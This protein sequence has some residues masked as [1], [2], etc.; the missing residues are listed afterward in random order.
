MFISKMK[1]LILIIFIVT[2][3]FKALSENYDLKQI[4]TLDDPW[5]SSFINKNEFIITEKTGKIKIVDISKKTVTEVKH[6][7][8]YLIVGQGGLLDIKYHDK[9]IWI[10]YT[11]KRENLKSSTT[12]ILI[13]V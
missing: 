8:N 5:G 10:S 12:Q 1:F 13:Y 7:L 2:Y 3:S 4:V 9:N 6:N 11:E